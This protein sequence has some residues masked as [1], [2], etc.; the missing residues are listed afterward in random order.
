MLT[1]SFLLLWASTIHN[2]R[3]NNNN[4]KYD[5]KTLAHLEH[6]FY[7]QVKISLHHSGRWWKELLNGKRSHHYIMQFR[8]LKVI[9][10]ISWA[11]I[12]SKFLV[13]F[14]FFILCLSLLNLPKAKYARLSSIHHKKLIY[15]SSGGWEDQN[16][17]IN[18]FGSWSGSSRW[19][20]GGHL[21]TAW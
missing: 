6:L 2:F 19:L 4:K 5:L 12:I 17:N 10:D 20:A 13:I 21:L 9:S 11:Y 18:P 7:F 14:I 1:G 3:I 16:Q 8:D 15:H